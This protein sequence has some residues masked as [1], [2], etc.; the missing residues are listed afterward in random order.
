[1]SEPLVVLLNKADAA[2]ALSMSQ[3]RLDELV[4]AGEIAAVQDGGRV[5]FRPAELQ[6]Y[7][8][9]L[10]NWEPKRVSA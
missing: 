8:D 5:K 10:P 9:A 1:M 6:R 4:A 3:R 2:A 7:A